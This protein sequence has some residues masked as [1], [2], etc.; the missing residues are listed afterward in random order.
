MKGQ[1]RVIIENIKPQVDCGRY[2]VKR[3]INDVINIEADIFCDGHDALS[4][5]LLYRH[6]D[7]PD[8]ILWKWNTLSTTG[9]RPNSC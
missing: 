2:P 7:Q 6:K 8:G 5:E 4:A 9:G 1:Q 3:V